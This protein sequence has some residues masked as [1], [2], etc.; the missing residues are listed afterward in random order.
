MID[1]AHER[2]LNIDLILGLLKKLLP[3]YPQMKLIV[4]SAT[5]DHK[6]FI[7]YFGGED[8]VG[9]VEFEGKSYGV[10]E[11]YRDE[12]D[13][14]PLDYGSVPVPQLAKNIHVQVSE[15]ILDLL[16][17]MYVK[18]GDLHTKRGD[19]LA[20]LHGVRPIE[21]AVALVKN[22]V[23]EIPELAGLVDVLPLYTTLPQ[24]KQDQALGKPDWMKELEG[25]EGY[26]DLPSEEQEIAVRE[27]LY[28]SRRRVVI[29]TN[30]AET[31]LTVH[32]ILHVVDCGII[33]QDAWDAQTQTTVVAP[34]L[35]SRAGCRQRWGR[36]GRLMA[37]DAYCLYTRQQFENDDIFEGYSK[38]QILRAPLE[39]IVLTAKAAGIDD[40]ENFPWIDHPDTKELQRAEMNLLKKKALDPDGDLTEHGLE[41]QSFS[42]EPNLANM[43][44]LADRFGCAIEMA[45]LVPIM[46]MGGFSRLLK[47]ERDWDA[48]TRRSV[49]R[50]HRAFVER[51]EDDIELCLKI[52]A[53]WSRSKEDDNIS[54]SWAFRQVWPNYMPAIRRS[55]KE[56]LGETKAEQLT[57]ALLK[58]ATPDELYDI[59]AELGIQDEALDSWLVQAVAAIANARPAAWARLFFTNHTALKGKIEVERDK[60][61]DALSAHK[62]EDERRPIDF[63]LLTRLRIIFAYSLPE[64]IYKLSD[65]LTGEGERIY[66]PMAYVENQPTIPAVI[67]TYSTCYQQDI[68]AFVCS[69]QQTI[70]RRLTPDSDR[71]RL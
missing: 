10:T 35:H 69:K 22:G 65:Q 14:P 39:Q 38:P 70:M 42:E 32:G 58:I 8:Q 43:M 48:N 68:E 57:N 62:K 53:A 45:T 34:V 52:Y 60:L 4:A 61:I 2:I 25:R 3:R 21:Q 49:R 13:Q 41:L 5:I 6:N 20:F 50:I 59:T 30:V 17:R 15:Q 26:K 7:R 19:I 66:H 55:V 29:S 54:D 23:E 51:C 36:A 31:S 47:R 24:E 27:A 11:H 33:N 44:V 12:L 56:R 37:G 67:G 64:R 40:L 16:Q 18:D 28:R 9:F 63:D 46:K 1:E 71:I